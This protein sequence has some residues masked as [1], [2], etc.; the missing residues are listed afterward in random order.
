MINRL[1]TLKRDEGF[2]LIELMIVMVVLGI[3]AGI[4]LFAVG[5]F[6]EAANESTDEAN[7]KICNTASAAALASEASDSYVDFLDEVPSGGCT[8]S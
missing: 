4:V 3:L 1:R 5:A 6:D 7:E 2:T 8:F